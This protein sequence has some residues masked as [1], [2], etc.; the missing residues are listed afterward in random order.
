M[1][2]IWNYIPGLMRSC[3]TR[4]VP[5]GSNGDNRTLLSQCKQVVNFA[6]DYSTLLQDPSP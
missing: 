6:Y 5:I 2:P 3:I 4:M 1:N